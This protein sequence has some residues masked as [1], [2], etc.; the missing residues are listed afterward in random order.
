MGEEKLKLGEEQDIKPRIVRAG[1]FFSRWAMYVREGDLMVVINRGKP[2]GIM[3]PT[4][5]IDRLPEECR[6]YMRKL[7]TEAILSSI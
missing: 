1:D 3:I 7:I 4:T 5:V 2:V 6:D